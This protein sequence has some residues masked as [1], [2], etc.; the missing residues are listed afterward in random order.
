MSSHFDTTLKTITSAMKIAFGFAKGVK[1][2]VC[3]VGS[4]E[5]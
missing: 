3:N 5:S 2:T 1:K 4:E